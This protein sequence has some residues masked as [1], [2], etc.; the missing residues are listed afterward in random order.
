MAPSGV[1]VLSFARRPYRIAVL[2]FQAQNP[3]DEDAQIGAFAKLKPAHRA[4]AVHPALN[5]NRGYLLIHCIFNGGRR[6][7]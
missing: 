7:S 4:R 5:Y 1:D 6:M 2:L 3:L